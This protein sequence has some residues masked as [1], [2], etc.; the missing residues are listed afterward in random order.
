MDL[1]GVSSRSRADVNAQLHCHEQQ[2]C[3][4][5]VLCSGRP[6]DADGLEA[7]R[8][9]VHA[10]V[11]LDCIEKLGVAEADEAK[12]ARVI[13]ESHPKRL[14]RIR[15]RVRV[16]GNLKFVALQQRSQRQ[17]RKRSRALKLAGERADPLRL[18]MDEH[19][20]ERLDLVYVYRMPVV[21][22]QLDVHRRVRVVREHVGLHLLRAAVPKRI[23]GW[24]GT[25]IQLVAIDDEDH[26]HAGNVCTRIA[27][28]VPQLVG[29]LHRAAVVVSVSGAQYGGDGFGTLQGHRLLR[30][31]KSPTLQRR[32]HVASRARA[33]TRARF[34]RERVQAVAVTRG[35]GHGGSA[36]ERHRLV[37]V[38]RSKRHIHIGGETSHFGA[39][40]RLTEAATRWLIGHSRHGQL[41]ELSP[42]SSCV[43]VLL[44]ALAMIVRRRHELQ[45]VRQRRR[46]NVVVRAASL[47][48]LIL[49]VEGEDARAVGEVAGE[50]LATHAVV[51][52]SNKPWGGEQL[53]PIVQF[54]LEAVVC[55]GLRGRLVLP[56]RVRGRL[57]ANREVNGRIEAFL[58]AGGAHNHARFP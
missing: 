15:A 39:V 8:A 19:L 53:E 32:P 16:D 6:L 9:C 20:P 43:H 31:K 3:F 11:H 55:R 10:P 25:F 26:L 35:R 24:A 28:L 12:D 33:R 17:R 1:E 56:P 42:P 4:L 51:H 23:G 47:V 44:R 48:Q 41:G 22:P 7:Q 52:F 58:G 34:K 5:H 54:V 40:C 13:V 57:L 2:V 36:A 38:A 37:S 46:A 29:E 30:L 49:V 18:A 27:I 14:E 45:G 21:A 50:L